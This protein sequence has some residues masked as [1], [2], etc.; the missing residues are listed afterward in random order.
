MDLQVL[1]DKLGGMTPEEIRAHLR[2]EG[3]QGRVSLAGSCPL[4]N[5]LTVELGAAVYV[6]RN[7]VCDVEHVLSDSRDPYYAIPDSMTQ[8][9]IL[10]DDGLYPELVEEGA[11]GE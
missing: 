8:F 11:S 10:F 7:W 4:A 9:T 2:Q 1:I 6:A 3:I 5:Y